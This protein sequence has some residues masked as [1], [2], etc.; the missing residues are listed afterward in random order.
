[1]RKSGY[2]LYSELYDIAAEKLKKWGYAPA[3][4]KLNQAAFKNAYILKVKQR[5]KEIAEGKRKAIGNVYRDIVQREMATATAKQ[6][7]KLQEVY[8]KQFGVH[9]SKRQI[10]YGSNEARLKADELNIEIKKTYKER[11][12]LGESPE[13]ALL[14][15]SKHYYGS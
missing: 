9:L 3:D 5:K 15:I 12:K 2:E 8:E 14:Y 1:M 11:R 6:A 4:D 10:M 7:P 13:T